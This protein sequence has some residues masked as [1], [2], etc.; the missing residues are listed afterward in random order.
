MR[1]EQAWP[2]SRPEAQAPAG[3][4]VAE[5][6]FRKGGTVCIYNVMASE[7]ASVEVEKI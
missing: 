2:K 3:V 7:S 6:K 4:V 5:Y 1:D